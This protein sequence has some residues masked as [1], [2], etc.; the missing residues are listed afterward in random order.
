MGKEEFEALALAEAGRAHGHIFVIDG[1]PYKDEL[2]L[3][4][5]VQNALPNTPKI[6]FVNQWDKM[7]N[8]PRKDRDIVCE[9]IKQ[10]MGKFVASPDDIVYGSAQ[11]Y[12]QQSDTMIRQE[13]PQLL[14]R[15]YEGAGTLGQVMN[16]LDPA[17]RAVQL[18]GNIR[19][20][21]YQVRVS[22][23]RKVI[24]AFGTAS[25]AGGFVPFT[26]LLVV[27][28][29][30]GSMVYV[31]CRIMGKPTVTKDQ[32]KSMAIELAKAC[33][34]EIGA[35]FAAEV[36]IGAAL[37]VGSVLTGGIAAALIGLGA[38]A[39]LG[40][41]RYRRTVVLGEVTV[42]YIKND[43]SW[44][45]EGRHAVIMKCRERAQQHYMKLTKS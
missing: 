24:S 30:L 25:V 3:F 12:D 31:V 9:R 44:G 14:D 34:A 23:A 27:P 36:G 22:I 10:K 33:G 38:L 1:E 8:T 45:G 29:V 5:V 7:Q 41:Y 40:Y 6:V 37:V 11:L 28:G 20:K 32:A 26:Q 15:M 13:L 19:E 17:N 43:F 35:E 4:E 2:D 16:V 18:G 39:G 21:I 42:E